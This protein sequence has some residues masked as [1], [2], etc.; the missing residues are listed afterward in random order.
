MKKKLIALFPVLVWSA[1][2]APAFTAGA[3]DGLA[4]TCPPSAAWGPA[5]PAGLYEPINYL[6]RK[7]D[8]LRWNGSPV[9]EAA[10]RTY[11]ETIRT[12]AEQPIILIDD[13]ELDCA[14]AQRLRAYVDTRLPCT[15]ALCRFGRFDALP[16]D[17]PATP[18]PPPPAKELPMVPQA[19]SD[20]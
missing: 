4:E 13:R 15:P 16:P 10:V 9:D 2:A 1:S 17:R 5:A 18:A 14:T 7:S 12:F 11:I 8:G 6:Y 20:R 19:P 3:A